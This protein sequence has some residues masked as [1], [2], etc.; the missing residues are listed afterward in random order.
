MQEQRNPGPLQNGYQGACQGHPNGLPSGPRAPQ[1]QPP[2][3]AGRPPGPPGPGDVPGYDPAAVRAENM[4][5]AEQLAAQK[6][7]GAGKAASLSHEQFRAALQMVVAAGDPR[8]ELENLIKIGEGSSGIV[9]IATERR[10]RKQVVVKRMMVYVD[11]DGVGDYGEDGVD[12]DGR[13]Q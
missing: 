6:R 5:R 2:R 13:W 8:R 1:G 3:T 4:A 12:G 11:G 10:S 9:C 7:S